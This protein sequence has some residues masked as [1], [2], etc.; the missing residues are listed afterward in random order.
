MKK[1][2]DLVL[3][4][5]HQLIVVNKPAGV[6][7][8]QDKTGD[9]SMHRMAMAYA[10]RDLYL[11]HRLDRR[12]SGV[13]VMAK[14]TDVAKNL[15]RQWEDNSVRKIYLAIVP[16]A[17]IPA[18]GDLHHHLTYDAKQN[19]TYAQHEPGDNTDEAKL[20]YSIIHKLDNFMILRIELITGRKHQIRAQLA[21]LGIP[22]RGDIKYGSKRTNENGAIDLH[23][24]EIELE[25]PARHA[26]M[27]FTAPPPEEGLW[28]LM[29]N[30]E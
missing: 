28:K 4:K 19:I 12:V 13:L 9:A 24:Y 7:T 3:Y 16:H 1:I 10:H 22:V 27:K 25:H 15:A 21:A 23:A 5:D 14:K 6:P 18:S 29:G 30:T 2:S 20:S 8:Q 26:R 11:V 17:D